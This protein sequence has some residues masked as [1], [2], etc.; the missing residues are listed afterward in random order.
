[1]VDQVL[2]NTVELNNLV[3]EIAKLYSPKRLVIF[4][5]SRKSGDNGA[6]YHASKM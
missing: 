6:F 5:G 1:M 4:G 3:V 2:K